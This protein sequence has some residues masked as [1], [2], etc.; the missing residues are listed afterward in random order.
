MTQI[1]TLPTYNELPWDLHAAAMAVTAAA[2]V[3]RALE[4]TDRNDDGYARCADILRIHAGPRTECG[5]HDDASSADPGRLTLTTR[6]SES[7]NLE[8]RRAHATRSVLSMSFDCTHWAA[9][10][11]EAH[12]STQSPVELLLDQ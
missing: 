7:V 4:N 9:A 6:G 8:M 5:M 2:K 11:D 10:I 3:S 12:P 1:T